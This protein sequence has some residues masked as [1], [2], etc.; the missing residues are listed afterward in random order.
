VELQGGIRVQNYDAMAL[1]DIATAGR[2]EALLGRGSS[3][4]LEYRV[5]R[6][7]DGV[8][9]NN[10]GTGFAKVELV[11]WNHSKDA[12]SR[13]KAP[14][15]NEKVLQ[16]SIV[17]FHFAESSSLIRSVSWCIMKDAMDAEAPLERGNGSKNVST[18]K[19][20]LESQTVYPSMV[21]FDESHREKPGIIPPRQSGENSE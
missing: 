19:E 14:T 8:A 5:V 12:P 6:S 3:Y 9:L 11:A 2:F 16:S 21:S 10:D 17:S 4:E 1:F 13:M 7:S 15:E 18:A 20:S